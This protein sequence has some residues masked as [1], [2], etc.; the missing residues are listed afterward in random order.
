MI[1]APAGRHL[2]PGRLW[3]TTRGEGISAPPR[4]G[5]DPSAPFCDIALGYSNRRSKA[6]SSENLHAPAS[7]SGKKNLDLYFPITSLMEHT[8]M[9]LEW[10][11]K[12]ASPC[13]T[14]LDR[15][16]RLPSRPPAPR[17]AEGDSNG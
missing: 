15:V 2:P 10:I 1:A 13:A 9:L 14:L 17:Q 3:R 16:N 7:S 6:M 4:V 5:L 12:P 11:P 8:S